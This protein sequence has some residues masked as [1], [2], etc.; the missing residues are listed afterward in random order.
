MLWA[1][2]RDSDKRGGWDTCGPAGQGR[3]HRVHG[4]L[5]TKTLTDCVITLEFATMLQLAATNGGR[6]RAGQ[7]S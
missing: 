2:K 3:S 1:A 5:R 4:P 6:L 7:Q